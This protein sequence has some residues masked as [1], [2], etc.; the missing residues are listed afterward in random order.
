MQELN[1]WMFS[2]WASAVIANSL[3]ENEALIELAHFRT[4]IDSDC[5][6]ICPG[7]GDDADWRQTRR[8]NPNTRYTAKGNHY[9]KQ[10]YCPRCRYSFFP[11]ADTM[12]ERSRE[13]LLMW[14]ALAD[15]LTEE[16]IDIITVQKRLCLTRDTAR[17]MLNCLSTVLNSP[18]KEKASS[19]AAPRPY[20][21]ASCRVAGP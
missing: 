10:V 21:V 2:E 8:T 16:G 11:M 4:E 3:S 5:M 12:F 20:R 15:L 1:N 13:P 17:R 14:I 6:G 19:L 7:C 18:W 9:T